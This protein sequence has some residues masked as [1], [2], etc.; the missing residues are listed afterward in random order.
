ME[1]RNAKYIDEKRIDCEINH[2]AFGWVPYT[3]DP[4]DTD[5]TIDNNK[6][7]ADMVGSGNIAAYTPPTQGEID[8]QAAAYVRLERDDKLRTEVD[9]I[10]GNALRWAALTDAERQSWADYRQ[11]LLDV[12]QKSGFPHNVIWPTKP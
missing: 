8:A 11:A 5:M 2:P 12:P 7:L 6:L 3:L 9:K 10:A 4:S 1:Y